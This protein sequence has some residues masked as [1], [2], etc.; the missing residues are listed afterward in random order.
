MFCLLVTLPSLMFFSHDETLN[1][2][3]DVDDAQAF[4]DANLR[5]DGLVL[6]NLAASGDADFDFSGILSRSAEDI[7]DRPSQ[8]QTGRTRV[9]RNRGPRKPAEPSPDIKLR[10]ARANTLYVA[11]QH[12][13]AKQELREIIRINAEFTG[14]YETLASIF[15]DEDKPDFAVGCYFCAAFFNPKIVP[16]WIRCIDYALEIEGYLR[17]KALKVAEAACAAMTRAS[18]NDLDARMKK[19]EVYI[20]NGKLARAINEYKYILARDRLRTAALQ[21]LAEVCVDE[22]SVSIAIQEYTSSLKQFRDPSNES[23]VVFEWEDVNA[24]IT[25]YEVS[26]NFVTAISELKSLARW[27]L[28]RGEETFWDEITGDDREWDLNESRRSQVAVYSP[29]RYPQSTYGIDLPLELRVKLGLCR[30]HLGNYN[31]A[32]V[33]R[34][35]YLAFLS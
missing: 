23:D 19:A 9:G 5:P 10:M 20:E 22:G 27:L 31:E 35:R 13:D 12:E 28:G 8:E 18:P 16:S 7:T 30:L 14:S 24:Y 34:A 29:E 32:M 1:D 4:A 33:S 15:M 21:K 26:G 2:Y 17:P 25:L 11:G 6:R 3:A